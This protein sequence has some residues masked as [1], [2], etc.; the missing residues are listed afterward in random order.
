M[1]V[2]LKSQ[3]LFMVPAKCQ[4]RIFLLSFPIIPYFYRYIVYNLRDVTV[5]HCSESAI[6]FIIKCFNK[7]PY[8]RSL[9]NTIQWCRYNAANFLKD[10]QKTPIPRPWWCHQ[11]ETFSALLVTSV[12]G[13]FTGHQWIPLTKAS[14]AEL[15]CFLWSALNKRLGK[16]SRGWWFEARSRPLWHH[17][18]TVT[19]LECFV[20]IQHLTDILPQFLQLSMQYL[21]ILER[22]ITV[23]N[24]TN[25]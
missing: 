2:A 7:W 22:V 24:C 14:D 11:M 21:T 23:L 19:A 12:C 1:R 3:Y 8:H 13:E 25:I 15:W 10:S 4:I 9:G 17:R 16:Q 20:Y 18:N 6:E 5:I